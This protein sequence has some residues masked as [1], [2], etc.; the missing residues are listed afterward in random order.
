MSV[1]SKTECAICGRELPPENRKNFHDGAVVCRNDCPGDPSYAAFKPSPTTHPQ[2]GSA[3]EATT[4][5]KMDRQ[6]STAIA[7]GQHLYA[8]QMRRWGY[9]EEAILQGR[10]GSGVDWLATARD[11]ITFLAPYDTESEL[12]VQKAA[13]VELLRRMTKL[14]DDWRRS[15]GLPCTVDVLY[16]KLEEA[17][18][19]I[20]HEPGCGYELK[21]IRVPCTCTQ[22]TG[23]DRL[24]LI[25]DVLFGTADFEALPAPA[26]EPSPPDSYEYCTTTGPRKCWD[27]L[28]DLTKEGWEPD[29]DRGQPGDSWDRFDYHEE[30]YWR[31]LK[32]PAAEG[33]RQPEPVDC[34]HQA[35]LA[36]LEEE[37]GHGQD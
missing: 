5:A 7:L 23:M 16:D 14:D 30:K 37:R 22:S 34:E 11:A 20:V 26:A 32:A 29:P 15:R 21:P 10:G 28:P 25:R 3:E 36:K 35:W 9:T 2:E 31:R 1:N 17:M 33:G 18:D 8:L 13:N 12:A 4:V 6:F 27:G 24:F 19:G